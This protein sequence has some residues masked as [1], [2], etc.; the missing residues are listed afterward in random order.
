MK[1]KQKK[2]SEPKWIKTSEQLPESGNILVSYVSRWGVRHYHVIEA[3]DLY[4]H[5]ERTDDGGRLLFGGEPCD[6]WRPFQPVT[7]EG[8]GKSKK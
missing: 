2:V 3:Q 8:K 6:Y 5:I 7:E 4:W 1:T